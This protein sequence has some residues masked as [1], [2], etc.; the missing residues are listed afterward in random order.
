FSVIITVVLI[1]SLQWIGDVHIFQY[2]SDNIKTILL[3]ALAYFPIGTIWSGFKWYLMCVDSRES[4]KESRLKGFFKGSVSSCRP[5]AAENKSRIMRWIG[6]WPTSVIW[7]V[8]DDF[9][10]R[11][12]RTIYNHISCYFDKI[13]LHVFKDM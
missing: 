11:I 8:L 7:T 6:Y 10:T 12:V 3:C 1:C 5:K 13:S 9:L 2:V 4:F